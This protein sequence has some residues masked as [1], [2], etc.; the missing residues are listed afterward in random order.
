LN[1]NDLLSVPIGFSGCPTFSPSA[2]VT[3]SMVSAVSRCG[4]PAALISVEGCVLW[5]RLGLGRVMINVSGKVPV[6]VRFKRLG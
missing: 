5:L 3:E 1:V 2:V 6:S 4:F